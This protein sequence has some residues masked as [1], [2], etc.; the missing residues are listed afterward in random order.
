VVQREESEKSFAAATTRRMLGEVLFDSVVVAGHLADFKWPAGA[1]AE[2]H[3]PRNPGPDR[4]DRSGESPSAAMK[5]STTAPAMRGDG[6]DLESTLKL[7]FNALLA[8][9]EQG[10][11]ESMRAMSDEQIEA[12]RMAAMQRERRATR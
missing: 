5:E 2:G 10:E 7:D 1:N 12:E 4:R 6:Y 11:L 8:K 9:Q 3:H